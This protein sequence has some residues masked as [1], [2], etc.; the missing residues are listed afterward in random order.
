MIGEFHFL[1]PWWIPAIVP[2]GLLWWW[3]RRRAD[4]ARSWRRVIAPHLLPYLLRGQKRGARFGPLE[5]AG[6]GWLVAVFAVAG[7]TWQREPAPF[8]DD[9]AA[10]AI[11]V[12][13]TPSMMADDVQ[14][15]RLA[16]AVEKIHDLLGQRRDA[17]V[18]LVVYAGT[19]H[20][21]VPVTTDDGII[22]SFSQA[23]DPRV[24]PAD[25]DAA[26]EGLRLADQ[27]LAD[28]GAGSIL[29][30][31]DTVAPE[32]AAPLAAWRKSSRTPVQL[33]PPLLAGPELQLLGSAARI[34]DASLVRLAADDSDVHTLAR[35]AKF[36]KAAGGGADDHWQECGY[37]LTPALALLSLP[38]FRRGYMLPTSSRI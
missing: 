20:V 33:F 28:A 22:G 11:V 38:F 23:L 24:M 31:A 10:L 12:K 2:V 36:S 37:W 35:A 30:I 16:R 34:A 13:V 3:L 8:A 21:V 14:P 9:T 25:G 32:Q 15:H 26:A 7:P 19:A 18:S 17:K 1:R 6:V 29:W 4:A 27:T 5:L